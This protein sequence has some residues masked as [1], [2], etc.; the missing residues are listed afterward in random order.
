M[1][2]YF[3][4]AGN[5]WLYGGKIETTYHSSKQLEREI[6]SAWDSVTCDWKYTYNGENNITSEAHFCHTAGLNNWTVNF[7]SENIMHLSLKHIRSSLLHIVWDMVSR[8][9]ISYYACA[10]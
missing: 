6:Y 4:T 3:D 1:D 7:K 9:F 5:E 10:I 2:Y 8:R